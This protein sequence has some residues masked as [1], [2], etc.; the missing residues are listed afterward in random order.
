MRTLPAQTRCT[1]KL[2]PALGGSWLRRNSS[3]LHSKS[4]GSTPRT[5]TNERRNNP[6]LAGN[7]HNNG[8]RGIHPPGQG[9]E[10]RK[11][12]HIDQVSSRQ[13]A[14]A[15]R[16][17]VAARCR[18]GRGKSPR[19]S[20]E[21]HG[22]TKI[23]LARVARLSGKTHL[24]HAPCLGNRNLN[25]SNT[26]LAHDATCRMRSKRSAA[27]KEA[28]KITVNESAWKISAKRPIKGAWSCSAR[29]RVHMSDTQP[30]TTK[31][32]AA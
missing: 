22:S 31:A 11:T 8:Q 4:T 19:L 13:R 1:V 7:N 9:R 30:S 3:D 26:K 25:R 12:H 28:G 29:M 21:S 14:T 10:R 17:R 24:V 2:H 16:C 6:Q 23:R 20:R 15:R 18:S 5:R 32:A 27:K